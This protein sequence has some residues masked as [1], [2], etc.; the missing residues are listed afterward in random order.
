MFLIHATAHIIRWSL[1][2]DASLLYSH[3]TGRTGVAAVILGILIVVPMWLM[4]KYVS[5]ALL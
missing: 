3:V 5:V 4:K 1:D 2:G